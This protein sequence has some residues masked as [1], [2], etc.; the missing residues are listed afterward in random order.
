MVAQQI[1][2]SYKST[3]Y[4]ND[5]KKTTWTLIIHQGEY[6]YMESVVK[7]CAYNEYMLPGEYFCIMAYRW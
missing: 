2:N 1:A 4:R 5:P 3:F 7:K 6:E